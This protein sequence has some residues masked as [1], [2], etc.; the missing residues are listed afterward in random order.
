MVN[1]PIEMILLRYRY[2]RQME[3]MSNL[4]LSFSREGEEK[5]V[6]LFSGTGSPAP[7]TYMWHKPPSLVL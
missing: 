7:Y 2:L 6:E 3:P 5:N 4:R 1:R